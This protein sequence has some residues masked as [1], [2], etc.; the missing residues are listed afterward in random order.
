MDQATF[1]LD[2]VPF[3]A[4]MVKAIDLLVQYFSLMNTLT[5]VALCTLLVMVV[6]RHKSNKVCDPSLY[7]CVHFSCRFMH[8]IIS[9]I[10]I[11][12]S[13]IGISISV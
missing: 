13:V 6:Q 10:C 2:A 5:K 7:I 12:I 1:L 3:R 11:S 8:C 4:Q 9:V